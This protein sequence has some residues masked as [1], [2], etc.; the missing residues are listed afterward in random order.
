MVKLRPLASLKG[1]RV[2]THNVIVG[3]GTIL[4][5]ALGVAFQSIVSHRLTPAEFGG[6]FAILTLLNLLLLPASALTL[7]MARQTSRDRAGGDYATSAAM[8]H[9]ANRFL[10]AGG[11]FVGL[12]VGVAS[13]WFSAPFGV[14]WQFVLAAAPGIPFGL[15]LP[16]LLGELQ[17]EQRFLAFSCLAAGQAGLKVAAAVAGGLWLGPVGVILG[18]SVAGCLSYIAARCLTRRKREVERQVQW[19]RPTLQYLGI[20]LP[21]T[22]AIAALLSADPLLVKYFFRPAEAGQYA[23]AVALGRA[24]YW[25]AG[26][27]ASVLFAKIIVREVRGGNGRYLV[28]AS[29][30]LLILGAAIGLPALSVGSRVLLAT[31]AGPSYA[32]AA[33]YLPLYS[34]GMTLFGIAII[35][36]ATQQS[37]GN[38]RFLAVL[39]PITVF[40]PVLIALFHQSLVQVVQVFDICMGL[41]LTGLLLIHLAEERSPF[42]I[43]RA[44]IDT[45]SAAP[46]EATP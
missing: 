37:R 35:L 22:L 3:A 41:L 7:A 40:E 16:L 5:G 20:V 13:P 15:A 46:L 18:V 43:N 24:I 45:L 33:I 39:V 4:A 31:F 9:G 11:C 27:V 32:A 44:A 10:I 1:E 6:V 38:A 12:L 25:G 30:V 14:P 21:S 17:G 8:L 36:I 19:L 23:V 2:V 29:L 28:G 42:G 26:G 34:L